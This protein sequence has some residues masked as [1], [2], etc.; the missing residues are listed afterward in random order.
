MKFG[1]FTN[2]TRPKISQHK[3]LK[4]IQSAGVSYSSKDPDIAI[5][6]GGDGTFGYYGRTL[7]IPMLFVG[8]NDPEL[9]GS[10]ARLAEIF[11]DDCKLFE[12][13]GLAFRHGVL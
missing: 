12:I 2:P 9:L 1:I 3:I 8:V 10:K 7:S 6:A 11:Y 5:V 13:E 4:L